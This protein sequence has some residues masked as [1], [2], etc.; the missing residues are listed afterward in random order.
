MTRREL[1]FWVLFFVLNSIIF[2]PGYV[3][4]S[5]ESSFIPYKGFLNGS[6][7]NRLNFLFE[8]DNADIFRLSIDVFFLICA[9][10]IL[11]NRLR[12]RLF[13]LFMFLYYLFVLLYQ[14]YHQSIEKIYHV[15]PAIYNDIHLIVMGFSLLFTDFSGVS[16]MV[17]IGAVTFLFVIYF[18][19]RTMVS[20]FSTMQFG[21]VSK[22]IMIA[23][24]IMACISI[25]TYGVHST[26][27]H[28]FQVHGFAAFQNILASYDAKKS[29]GSFDTEEF[30]RSNDYEKYTLKERPDI[31]FLFIE[32]YGRIVLDNPELFR[33]YRE[34]VTRNEHMLRK[35]HWH[36]SSH[37]SRS[38]VSGG[39]SWLSYASV[40]YGYNFRNEETYLSLLKNPAIYHYTHLLRFLQLNG[41]TNYRLKSIYPVYYDMPESAEANTRFYAVDRWIRFEDLQ[42]T[43]TLHGFGPSPNDQYSLNF[44]YNFIREKNGTNPYTLFFLNQ[45][46]HRP[47]YSPDRVVENWKTLNDGSIDYSTA[48]QLLAN[49]TKE[50]YSR[51]VRFQIDYLTDFILRNV[52]EH[53]IVIL[54]GDHQPPVLTGNRNGFETP[55][56]IISKDY[57]FVNS[58]IEYGFTE[59]MLV[60]E[61][62]K[63]INHEGFYSMFIREFVRHYGKEDV[64]LPEYRPRGIE[65]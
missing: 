5:G 48:S 45:N 62:E 65:F 14:I 38:P 22:L 17:V 64:D 36:V 42:Y 27:A 49:S 19:I 60:L 3:L 8:R 51:A 53:D 24:A 52:D 16:F 7:L 23:L 29:L 54:M 41:Y 61:R 39:R 4:D 25:G 44:A 40:L 15:A 28:G 55:V 31:Y 12:I 63:N 10:Y 32:S 30:L 13:P 37:L 57:S 58:F 59:G 26:S 35:N 34:Y 47:F 56:H 11:K 50:D 21:M 33:D 1:K 43:G 18:L 6:I 20:L 46:S 2:L 9:V